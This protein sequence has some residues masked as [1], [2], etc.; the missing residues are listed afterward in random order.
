MDRSSVALTRNVAR[1]AILLVLAGSAACGAAAPTPTTGLTGTVLRGPIT[2]VC[3][4]NADCDAPF[5]AG[6]SVT[7]AA[8]QTTLAHF[9][10]DPNGRFTVMLQPG[11][12]RV[13][14]DSDAPILSPASQVKTVTVGASGL[15]SV[16][17]QFDTG[18]R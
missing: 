13:V 18:I 11:P 17:L 6:F 4:P 14:P 7:D 9:Q 15:T 8:G 5:S 2:P 16:E 3:Q 1:L 10:S 12:C